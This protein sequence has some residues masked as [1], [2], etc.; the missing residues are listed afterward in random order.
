MAAVVCSTWSCK[1]RSLRISQ[2]AG[3]LIDLG[4]EGGEIGGELVGAGALEELA[5]NGR[6]FTGQYLRGVLP[7]VITGAEVA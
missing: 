2:A 1:H 5:Q 7:G 3:Y 6:A 4:P